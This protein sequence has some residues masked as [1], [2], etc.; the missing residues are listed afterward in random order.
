MK[1]TVKGVA[2]TEFEDWKQG[3]WTPGYADLQKPE[4]EQLL[5]AL[6]CEQ[7]GVCCYCWRSISQ[8]DS[9]IEHFRPRESRPDL[10]LDYANLHVH[11]VSGKPSLATRF[12][13][14]I[15]KAIGLRKRGIFHRKTLIVNRVL[16]SP[17]RAKSCLQKRTMPKLST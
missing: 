1:H 4:K 15:S 10:A 7:G 3:D 11:R 12:I 14:V 13:V 16:F 8:A 5:A 2:P 9:H 17:W 6:L